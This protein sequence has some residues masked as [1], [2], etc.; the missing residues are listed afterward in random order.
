MPEK[1]TEKKPPKK[2]QN[3]D[4]R[5]KSAD[6]GAVIPAEKKEKISAAEF[7][8]RM[9]IDKSRVSRG[10]E[11]GIIQASVR[12]KG[13]QWA[14]TW[15]DAREEWNA[16]IQEEHRP[17]PM[18]ANASREQGKGDAKNPLAEAYQRNRAMKEEYAAKT[19]Q[20]QFEQ[21]VKNLIPVEDVR[22][23]ALKTAKRTRDSFLALPVKV[24]A[25]VAAMDDAHEIEQLITDAV[26]DVLKDLKN[27]YT[28]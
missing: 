26:H 13:G 11:A 25:A 12:R 17:D 9:E 28:T 18:K 1:K 6:K 3:A 14:V 27:V 19:M 4:K 2:P 10:I 21:L 20:V 24:A 7:A 8:R 5:A 15:P 23:E 16:N 22:R